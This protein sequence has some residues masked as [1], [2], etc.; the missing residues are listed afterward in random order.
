MSG[1]LLALVVCPRFTAA[2]QT[3]GG[4]AVHFLNVSVNDLDE[5]ETKNGFEVVCF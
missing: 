5:Q 3:Q 2:R 1:Q 4:K